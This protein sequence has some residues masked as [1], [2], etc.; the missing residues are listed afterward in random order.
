MLKLVLDIR[1]RS[2]PQHPILSLSLSLSLARAYSL[3]GRYLAGLW[4]S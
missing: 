1:F 2:M 4:A 3:K